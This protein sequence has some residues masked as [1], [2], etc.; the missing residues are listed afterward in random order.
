MPNIQ[1][2]QLESSERP[3]GI[4]LLTEK[5]LLILIGKQ[6]STDSTLLPSSKSDEYIIRLMFREVMLKEE[7]LVT[8]SENQSGYTPFSA[9]LHKAERKK[10]IASLSPDICHPNRGLCK[11]LI[12]VV[13]VEGLE[14]PL[15][16]N[17]KALHPVS[18]RTPQPWKLQ[19]PSLL[20]SQR[21]YPNPAAHQTTPAP[22]NLFIF[23]KERTY[24]GKRKLISSLR[25]WK[26]FLGN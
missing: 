26:F 5:L 15:F 8:V 1:Q 12:A 17:S 4:C 20:S 2:I 25:N 23:L 22:R 9:L 11:Q 24:N 7:F 6:K 10:R 21:R 16:K 3:K 14:G 13:K 18:V 19:M